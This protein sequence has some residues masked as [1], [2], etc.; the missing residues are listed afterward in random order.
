MMGEA[1]FCIALY[2]LI[3][4]FVNM[5]YSW[6]CWFIEIG[7]YLNIDKKQLDS[8]FVPVSIIDEYCCSCQMCYLSS[9]QIC[10]GAC[11]RRPG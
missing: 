6:F 5:T 3:F 9:A 2:I 1:Q 11:R 4:A 7:L 8:A 10:I